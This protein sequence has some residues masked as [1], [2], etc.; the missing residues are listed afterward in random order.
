MVRGALLDRSGKYNLTVS[1]PSASLVGECGPHIR[2]T[3]DNIEAIRGAD[4]IFVAVKPW[5]M[6]SVLRDIGPH[7]SPGQAVGSAAARITLGELRQFIGRDDIPLFKAIPNT[8][9]ALGS[10]VTSVA[11]GDEVVA[12]K[13][14]EILEFFASQGEVFEVTES[15]IGAVTSLTSCGIAY[16]LRYIDAS[17]RG[18]IQIGIPADESLRM[19]RQTVRGALALLDTNGTLPQAEI[20]RVTTPKGIT[21]QGLDTME[22][23]GFSEAVIA[24]L[25]AS[26]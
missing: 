18:G 26:K 24:G 7:L 8:A 16:A 6:E 5:V 10:G 12:E 19:V 15:Q 9:S 2:P 14:G 11:F 1:H 17:M 13:K 23:Q 20:N 22:N 21:L 4:M 3:R 25:E